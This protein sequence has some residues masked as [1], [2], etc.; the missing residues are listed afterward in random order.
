MSPEVSALLQPF[1]HCRS[2]LN[3]TAAAFLT[4]NADKSRSVVLPLSGAPASAWDAAA[5]SAATIQ[6]L[7]SRGAPATSLPTVF[8]LPVAGGGVEVWATFSSGPNGTAGA[9][10]MLLDAQQQLPSLIS[11]MAS[12]AG[13]VVSLGTV[14][15]TTTNALR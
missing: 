13:G 7:T 14:F 12:A 8:T 5:L 9:L 11:G 1:L 3:N 10:T 6:Y 15:T 4:G 2:T